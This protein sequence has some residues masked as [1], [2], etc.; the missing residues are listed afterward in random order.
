M[1][2]TVVT[3]SAADVPMVTDIKKATLPTNFCIQPR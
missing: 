1:D 3:L 2:A